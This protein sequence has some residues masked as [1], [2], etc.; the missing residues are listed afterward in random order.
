M[1]SWQRERERERE[2]CPSDAAMVERKTERIKRTNFD[3]SELHRYVCE[4]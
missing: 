1:T 2:R 4:T 3:N